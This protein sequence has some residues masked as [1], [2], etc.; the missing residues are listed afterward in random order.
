MPP[1]QTYAE[2]HE[3]DQE[4]SF[5]SLIKEIRDESIALF[6]QE[7]ELARTEVTEKAQYMGRQAFTLSQ[8]VVVAVAG[9]VV[10]LIGLGQGLSLLLAYSGMGAQA[11]WLGPTIVGLIVIAAGA[12]VAMTAKNKMEDESIVPEKTAHSMKENKQW[13]KDKTT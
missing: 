2:E 6:R 10:L 5:A 13:L 12:S 4:R 1:T 9:L 7:V 11:I 3:V 8:G